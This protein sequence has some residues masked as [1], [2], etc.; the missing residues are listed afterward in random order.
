MQRLQPT[1][2]PSQDTNEV[3]RTLNG[4]PSSVQSPQYGMSSRQS[5]DRS[6]NS[7]R[8]SHERG[9]SRA[10]GAGTTV[11][12]SNTRAHLNSST[13][14]GYRARRD[15]PGSW[16]LRRSTLVNANPEPP[17]IA[18]TLSGAE[19]GRT[20]PK[21]TTTFSSLSKLSRSIS[22]PRRSGLPLELLYPSDPDAPNLFSPMTNVVHS[23]GRGSFY[24][25]AIQD[26]QENTRLRPKLE[27][28]A[29]YV[30]EGSTD[31]EP[32]ITKYIRCAS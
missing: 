17:N 19:E 20:D 8:E 12:G 26:D 18:R 16:S 9:Y 10:S 30:D 32:V 3:A 1:D 24:S 13:V 29:S 11:A 14:S 2:F 7:T 4:Y 21:V 27:E 28:Q 22:N 23:N 5:I 6:S 31:G 15:V 25:R